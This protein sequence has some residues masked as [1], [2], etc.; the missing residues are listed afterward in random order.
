MSFEE[1]RDERG[2]AAVAEKN[3]FFVAPPMQAGAE[4]E[5][6]H[7]F[8]FPCSDYSLIRSNVSRFVENT[9]GLPA[10]AQEFETFPDALEIKQL[11]PA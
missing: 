2:S 5:V 3:S 6:T 9:F 4:G 1:I 7:V 8:L 10:P 11:E